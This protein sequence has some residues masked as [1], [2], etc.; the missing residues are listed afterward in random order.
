MS[1]SPTGRRDALAQLSFL[2]VSLLGAAACS[3]ATPGPAAP[4][5]PQEQPPPP[6]AGA[7]LTGPAQ[8]VRLHGSNTIGLSLAPMLA[9]AFL[10]KLGVQNLT[11]NGDER[12][13]ERIWIQG[14]VKGSWT[15]FEIWAPG[16]KVGFTSLAKGDCDI[17]LASRNIKAEEASSLKAF[18]DMTS[19]AADHVIGIDGIA[20]IVHPSSR[21]TKLTTKQ[22]AAIFTG[23]VTDWSQ[24]GG[25]KAAI[26]VYT[27]DEKS[28][29]ADAFQ[30]IVLGGKG[31]FSAAKPFNDSEA[32]AAA[33]A[34]D[35]GGIGYVGLP[36]VKQ[37][38]AVSVQDGDATPLFPTVFT[39]ATEDYAL[40][41]R[42]HLYAP[43]ALKNPL[44]KTF[45][46]FVLSDEGQALVEQA[47]FVSLAV[48]ADTPPLPGGAPPAYEADIKGAQRLSVN[49]RFRTGSAQLDTKASR[50]VDRVL[51]F[52][53]A[54]ENRQRHVVLNGFA[55]NQG[56]EKANLDL[57]KSRAEVVAQEL[58][59]RGIS[60]E[61]ATGW[62]SA[63]PIAPNDTPDGR[64]RNRRVEL[65]IR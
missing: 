40:S 22:L 39:V 10:A 30:S 36:Y 15:S 41:R 21:L 6:A 62:G 29:T 20:V 53:S 65:W 14:N 8:V 13:S 58:R 57:S 35:E 9:K 63:L 51:R 37:V 38:K 52:L 43:E 2:M 19:P 54:P 64:E 45:L 28:G 31:V 3:E 7:A 50:D 23:E 49:F 11:V 17:A 12:K 55:D 34:G 18:G 47:G 5:A 25:A 1:T 42:L 61:R 33:V 4:P 26:H 48:K 46:D 60:P 27:R 24:V 44:A 32:L 16:S 56:A 59:Q